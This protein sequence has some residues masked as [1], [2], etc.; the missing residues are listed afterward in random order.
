MSRTATER[1]HTPTPVP[2]RH[3]HKMPT[4]KD[5]CVNEPAGL[6]KSAVG[7]QIHVLA[8]Q[9]RPRQEQP[10]RITAEHVPVD[11]YVTRIVPCRCKTRRQLGR[12]RPP[13]E[14]DQRPAG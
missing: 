8:L 2:T 7:S 13:A 3:M 5:G 10:H 1:R 12:T 11:M 9:D 14:V 6:A 4:H